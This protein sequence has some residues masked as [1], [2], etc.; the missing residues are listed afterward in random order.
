MKFTES[1]LRIIKTALSKY[2]ISQSK[3]MKDELGTA[4]ADRF[5]TP[6]YFAR[7]EGELASISSL[8]DK[9]SQLQD[10]APSDHE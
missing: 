7:L 2:L 6:E 1:E 10:L 9:I 4:G 5:L 3:L 8:A